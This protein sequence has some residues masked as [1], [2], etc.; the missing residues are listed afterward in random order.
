MTWRVGESER[1][2]LAPVSPNTV[3]LG[4]GVWCW[5]GLVLGAGGWGFVPWQF[6]RGRL[7]IA[8]SWSCW[9]V[10]VVLARFCAQKRAIVAKTRQLAGLGWG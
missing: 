1:D 8:L 4:G 3:Q 7:T 2:R 10:L 9:R 5:A 6:G